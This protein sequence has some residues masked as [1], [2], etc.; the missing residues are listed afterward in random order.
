MIRRGPRPTSNFT[1]IRNELGLDSRLSYRARGVL[2]AILVRPDNW[3][4]SAQ[5][6]SRQGVEGRDA[7]RSALRELENAGYL[8][9][10]NVRNSDG[11]FRF[12]AVIY[13]SPQVRPKPGNPASENQAS[14][15]QASDSQAPLQR[16]I[17]R[18]DTSRFDE[19]WTI[20]PRKVG[21]GAARKSWD[22]AIRKA[23]P[24]EIIGGARAYSLQ[25]SGQD[26]AFTAHPA[27]WLNA[28][29]WADEIDSPEPEATPKREPKP[30]C[31]NCYA[32]FLY[33]TDERGYEFAYA[34]DCQL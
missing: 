13:D 1:V 33:E 16:Q 23:E 4:T 11:T 15:I 21:K 34:C 9:R 3:K 5:A 19:F 26:Q 7:I 31:G 12:E 14:E 17:Q 25:R 8:V 22:K 24:E 6:L 28:E 27:T 30:L 32:G 29:R 10:Q 2:I 18:T 20:Y